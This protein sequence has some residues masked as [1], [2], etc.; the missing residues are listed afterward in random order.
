MGGMKYELSFM[1]VHHKMRGIG[2]GSLMGKLAMRLCFDAGAKA[3]YVMGECLED[4]KD[5]PIPE[6]KSPVARYW[7]RLGFRR[8]TFA[9]YEA[10]DE[11]YND[12][13]ILP[14]KMGRRQAGQDG[15]THVHCP[16]RSR[17][18]LHD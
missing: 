11:K 13:D 17:V 12:L 3:L 2:L 4:N 15:S 5:K 6:H 8:C 1:V 10:L 16:L 9:E 7:K 14:Y 18:T